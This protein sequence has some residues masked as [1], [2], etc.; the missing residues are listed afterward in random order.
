MK[1]PAN[2]PKTTPVQPPDVRAP[3]A[4]R[5][6]HVPGVA[7]NE[8]LSA[9]RRST[10]SVDPAL[11]QRAP[12]AAA[13]LGGSAPR[14]ASDRLPHLRTE[15]PAPNVAASATQGPSDVARRVSERLGDGS[16]ALLGQHPTRNVEAA[17]RTATQGLERLLDTV[18][19]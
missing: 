17:L 3:S 7:D 18:R 8:G 4:S 1:T 11:S 14:A 2:K 16:M 19:K 10:A 15:T 12:S 6:A 13:K 9:A 5:A